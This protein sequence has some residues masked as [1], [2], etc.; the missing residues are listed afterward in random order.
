MAERLLKYYKYIAE[1]MGGE[2]KVKLA[3]ETKIPSTMAATEDDSFENIELFKEAV[4][5]LTGRRAPEF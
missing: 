3:M 4:L 5:K 2:C 1:E